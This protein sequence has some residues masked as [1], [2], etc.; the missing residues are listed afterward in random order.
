MG[1]VIVLVLA[2]HSGNAQAY[3]LNV[4]D[5]IKALPSGYTEPLFS[6]LGTRKAITFGLDFTVIKSD[7]LSL[8]RL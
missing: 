5:C 4:E 2:I 8:K 6:G 1:L 7:R 3:P